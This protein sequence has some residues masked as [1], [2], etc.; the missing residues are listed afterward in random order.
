[1]SKEITKDHLGRMARDTVSGFKGTIIAV[2]YWMN[3]CLRVSIAPNE[4]KDGK[5]IE[6]D[7][8]DVQ[9]VELLDKP[10]ED[11]PAESAKRPGGPTINPAREPDPV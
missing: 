4:L 1:M 3:G 9:Q 5:R 7:T 2:T 6:S 10:A 8:F 11:K